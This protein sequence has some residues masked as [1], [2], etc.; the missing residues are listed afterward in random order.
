MPDQVISK[1]PLYMDY[2]TQWP[3]DTA[4]WLSTV[5]PVASLTTPIS[6]GSPA[7]SEGEHKI[8][9]YDTELRARAMGGRLAGCD[10]VQT[11][12]PDHN[13]GYGSLTIASLALDVGWEQD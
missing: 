5:L 6:V 10:I 2:T 1:A 3:I 7:Q 9:P 8:P 13:L 12:S 4:S 11:H